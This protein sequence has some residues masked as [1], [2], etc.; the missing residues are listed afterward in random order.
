MFDNEIKELRHNTQKA[1]EFFAQKLAYTL[2]PAE[3]KAMLDENK[4]KL[5]DVRRAED[6]SEA[7]I[8]GA[9][10]IPKDELRD[11][12]SM[13]S[14]EDVHVVS[15]YNQQCHLAA[16]AAYILTQNGYPTMEQEGGFKVWSEDFNYP[17][18]K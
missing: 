6:Y 2:G 13:L 11:K 15:C 7:H 3:L 16:S 18:E 9:I 4:V 5:I 12:L 14:K 17:T 10:S 8:P 1:N